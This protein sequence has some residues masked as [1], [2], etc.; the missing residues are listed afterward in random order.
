MTIILTFQDFWA[1][2]RSLVENSSIDINLGAYCEDYD[3]LVSILESV[4]QTTD[5]LEEIYSKKVKLSSKLNF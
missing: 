5:R 4:S 3:E 2:K 1:L